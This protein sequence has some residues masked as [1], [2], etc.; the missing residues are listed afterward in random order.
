MISIFNIQVTTEQEEFV[1]GFEGALLSLQQN[2]G[3]NTNDKPV[4]NNNT[5]QVFKKNIY[6]KF[7]A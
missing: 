4:K 1:K 6:V 2:K 3:N 5:Q 7:S